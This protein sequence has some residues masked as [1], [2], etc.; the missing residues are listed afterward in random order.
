MILDTLQNA[1]AYEILNPRFPLAFSRLRQLA[2]RGDLPEGRIDI[3]GDD[4]FALVVK[5][6][7]KPKDD[8]RTETH[9]RYID[10]QYT[11]DGVDL[12]GWIPASECVS[13]LGYDD[14][15]DLEFYRDRPADWLAVKQGKFAVFFPAD[16]HAPMA[17]TG[18]PITKIV[19]KV[20][21]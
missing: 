7:G 10:I 8:A 14:Q 15:K 9:R 20:A 11:A 13:A 6:S 21:V 18:Q 3:Q 4:I 16:A 2:V 19:I 17:N 12:I 5:G 1:P